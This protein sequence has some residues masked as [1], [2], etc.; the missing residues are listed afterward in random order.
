MTREAS[1]MEPTRIK[2]EIELS[3]EEIRQMMAKALNLGSNASVEVILDAARLELIKVLEAKN[4][5]GDYVIKLSSR[6]KLV[7]EILSPEGGYPIFL[8]RDDNHPDKLL[9]TDEQRIESVL[10]ILAGEPDDLRVI[11]DNSPSSEHVAH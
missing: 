5:L 7:Q 4:V 1:V 2:E 10:E 3:G 9:F 6:I 11:W 8:E